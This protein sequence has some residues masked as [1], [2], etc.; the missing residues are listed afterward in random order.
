MLLVIHPAYFFPYLPYFQLLHAADRFLF[1]DDVTLIRR[2]WAN[3]N[4][5]LM[6][7]QPTYL[8]IPLEGASQNRRVD[9][10]K[11]FEGTDWRRRIRRTV[12]RCYQ[13]APFYARGAA[14][15]DEVLDTPADSITDLARTSV[16]RT[17][18]LLG[19]EVEVARTSQ[20]HPAGDLRGQARMIEICKREGATTYLNAAA[21]RHLYDRP[22][23]DQAE[24][25]LRFLQPGSIEY[26]Q[27][28]PGFVPGLSILDVIMFNDLPQIASMLERY[29]V[30]P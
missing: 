4:R 7:G 3:R 5:V 8:T 25:E 21:G 2:G 30:V 1:L 27:R 13:R 14:L 11:I 20:R 9:E 18:Q 10:T 15:L 26:D 6:A 23:F 17:C 19:V 29:Q 24:L 22:S 16:L 12:Q 28:R